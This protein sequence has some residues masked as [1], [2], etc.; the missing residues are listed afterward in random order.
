[1]FPCVRCMLK[2]C[3]PPA[4]TRLVLPVAVGLDR[5]N[6][7]YCSDVTQTVTCSFSTFLHESHFFVLIVRNNLS[8]VIPSF[9]N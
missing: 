5:W 2:F 1:M 8:Q 4:K 7:S 9:P 3:A 6:V